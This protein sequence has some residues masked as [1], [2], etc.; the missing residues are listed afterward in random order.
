MLLQVENEFLIKAL[1]SELQYNPR[2][3]YLHVKTNG[4]Q[5]QPVTSREVS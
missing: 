4:G 5:W 1:H 3:V 2:H